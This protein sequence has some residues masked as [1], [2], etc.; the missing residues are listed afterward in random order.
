MDDIWKRCPRGADIERVEEEVRAFLREFALEGLTDVE[1]LERAIF[2]APAGAEESVFAP[3]LSRMR[4]SLADLKRFDE[5]FRKK[6]LAHVPQRM[7]NG[8]S[9]VKYTLLLKTMRDG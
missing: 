4:G 5:L 9:P 7:L 8:L 2:E 3:L 1:S 6:L